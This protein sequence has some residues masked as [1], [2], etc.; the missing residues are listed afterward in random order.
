MMDIFVNRPKS[1]A[2][3]YDDFFLGYF[4]QGDN[5]FNPVSQFDDNREW[6]A[7]S[8]LAFNRNAE[9]TTTDGFRQ[10]LVWYKTV[11]ED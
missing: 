4:F 2:Q 6:Q 10:Y 9:W 7:G 11:S 3:G 1:F 5:P 8:D